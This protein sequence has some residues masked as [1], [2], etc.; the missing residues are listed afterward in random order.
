[1]FH[2]KLINHFGRKE[3]KPDINMH[4]GRRAA[5]EPRAENGNFIGNTGNYMFEPK[6]VN[7]E[8]GIHMLS[9]ISLHIEKE[10]VIFRKEIEEK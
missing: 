8:I 5:S 2:N 10:L 9:L 6:H 1:M 3:S 4:E 7:D